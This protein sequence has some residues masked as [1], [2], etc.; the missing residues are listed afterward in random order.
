MAE[1][2]LVS[3]WTT[4]RWHIIVSQFGPTF[5]LT[6][7][8]FFVSG[9]ISEL[10]AA[11][12]IAAAGILLAAGILG[13]VA[14][15]SAANEGL[16]VIRDLQSLGPVRISATASRIV[17]SAPWVNIVRFVTPAIFVVIYLALLWAL[18]V[19]GD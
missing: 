5:L 1:H 7:S 18:F 16:A 17:K 3:L 2:E 4:A 15:I 19:P 14:Q 9:D 13:A 10:D 8:V 11:V 6:A 12:R